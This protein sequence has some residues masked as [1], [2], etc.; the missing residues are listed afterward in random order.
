MTQ[1]LYETHL[2]TR[3]ASACG[4]SSGAEY[5]KRYKDMGYTGIIITDHFYRG[6]NAINKSLPWHDW[7]H[8]FCQGYEAAKEEGSRRGLDVFFGWEETFTGDDYLVY[9]LDKEWLLEHPEVKSWTRKQQFDEVRQHNGCVVQA[10]PFRQYDYINR[11]CL[12]TGCVDAVEAANSGN[13]PS[14]DSLAWQYAKSLKLPI[15]AGSDIHFANVAADSFFGVYLDQKMESIHDFAAAVRSDK[16]DSRYC[17]LAGL[18]VPDG[19]FEFSGNERIILPLEIRDQNDRKVK[20]LMEL[21]F[22]KYY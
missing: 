17:K 5:V 1:Y 14:F 7:V 15:I 16:K 10:H 11:V 8:Q 2:H 21:D 13:D 19:R 3:E 18:K 20:S 9:G 4:K 6:N 12:S 22:L